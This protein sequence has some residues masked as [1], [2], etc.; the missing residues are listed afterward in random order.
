M[1][2][3]S[4]CTLMYKNLFELGF[5]ERSLTFVRYKFPIGILAPG[6]SSPVEL[7]MEFV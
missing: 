1:L 2:G 4:C 6:V 5:T 3:L 7:K